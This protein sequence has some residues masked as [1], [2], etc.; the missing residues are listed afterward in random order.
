MTALSLGAYVPCFNDVATLR[1]A[2]ESLLAQTVPPVEVVVIDDGSTDMPATALGGLDARVVRHE[3]NMGRGAA[4]ARAMRELEHEFVVCCDATNVL[5][6]TFVEVG[7][8]WFADD[9]V[10]AVV[11]R[12]AQPP[13]RNVAER[14]RGRH[15]FKLESARE[16]R[17]GASLSTGGTLVRASAVRQAGGYDPRLRHTEDADLSTR[18][19][20]SGFD[21][22]HDPNLQVLSIASNTVLQVLERYWRWYAGTAETV[23][24]RGYYR[25]IGF[26][27]KAMAAADLREGDP[28]SV[29]ISLA[30][31]HYQFWRSWFR[32]L[33]A[34]RAAR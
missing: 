3:R 1:C 6:P 31:P 21:I 2:V 9:R 33:R 14:W 30:T 8:P 32:Q 29:P 22:V 12:I 20:A 13:A 26:S 10:A 23:C 15:L 18:L 25:N 5:E 4:R 11:G 16:V 34:R 17:R 28:L 7:L 19:A 24:W 27:I